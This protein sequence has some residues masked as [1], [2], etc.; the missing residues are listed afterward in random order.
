MNTKDRV[1]DLANELH[2]TILARLVAE[3]GP[4]NL[5]AIQIVTGA[6]VLAVMH[7]VPLSIGASDRAKIY[8]VA[9]EAFT[10]ALTAAHES[11]SS[12]DTNRN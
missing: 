8:A 11:L 12:N 6:A 4:N 10:C 7:L 2:K 1:F 9:A 5:E 3:P